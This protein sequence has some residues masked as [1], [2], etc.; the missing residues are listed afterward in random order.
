MVLLLLLTSDEQLDPEFENR[1]W[2]D[3]SFTISIKELE[4]R[5]NKGLSKDSQ[6]DFL[7]NVQDTVVKERLKEVQR[8]LS[9]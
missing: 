7:S 6:Y 1:A 8:L 5:L 4:S 3:G 2:N 9:Q